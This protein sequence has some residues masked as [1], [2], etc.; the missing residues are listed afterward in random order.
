MPEPISEPITVT[1]IDPDQTRTTC[2]AYPGQNLMEVALAA[3]V[4]GVTGQ[5]GGAINCA[6]CLCNIEPNWQPH[7]PPPE[8]DERELLSAVD[9]ATKQSRLSCQIVA[10]TG[11]DGLVLQVIDTRN[12]ITN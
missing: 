3:G 1:F 9:Q 8:D 7:L 6:T 2:S 12:F 10:H 11:L 5:C 4:T